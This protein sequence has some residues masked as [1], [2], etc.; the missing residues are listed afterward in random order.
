MPV[1]LPSDLVDLTAIPLDELRDLRTP[2]LAHAI[3]RIYERAAISA[4]REIQEQRG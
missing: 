4:G 3:Q 1:D 2:A